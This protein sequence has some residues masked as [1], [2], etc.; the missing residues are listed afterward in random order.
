MSLVSGCLPKDLSQCL[1]SLAASLKISR[2]HW[3]APLLPFSAPKLSATGQAIHA[4]PP[5][6]P[7]W[8]KG[9]AVAQRPKSRR[10]ADVIH[11][12]GAS[13]LWIS[14]SRVAKFLGTLQNVGVGEAAEVGDLG[15]VR[16]MLWRCE[17]P[18]EKTPSPHPHTQ[19]LA[20]GLPREETGAKEGV[21]LNP[22]PISPYKSKEIAVGCSFESNQVSCHGSP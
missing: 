4:A 8:V 10:E 15:W 22:L 12:Q 17:L 7:R 14:L 19:R 6:K 5:H 1:S 18:G 3:L 11:S 16:G 20:L 2:S 13:R 9:G 21:H